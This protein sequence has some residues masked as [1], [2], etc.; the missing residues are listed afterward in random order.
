MVNAT[1]WPLYFRESDPVPIVQESGWASG[2]VW[3]NAE[4]LAPTGIVFVLSPSS[5]LLLCPDC[6]GLAFSPLLYNTNIPGPGG[7]RT[8]DPSKRSAADP[9]LRPLGHWDQQGFDPRTFQSVA[10]RYTD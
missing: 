6:P 5:V 7:I 3:T 8:R 2:S 10:S 4:N 1:P 9:R